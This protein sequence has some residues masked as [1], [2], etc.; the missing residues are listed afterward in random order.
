MLSRKALEV[1]MPANGDSLAERVQLSYLQLSSV[2]SD[3]NTVSD[4]LG[5][6]IAEIDFALKKL[7]L[8][9]SVWAKISGWEDELDYHR[10]ELGYAK[11]E[12]KWGIALRTVTGNYN[13]PDQDNIEQW[14][15]SD[16]PRRLRLASIETL[17][18][19][20]K[21]LSEEASETTNKIK[22]KLAEVKEVAAAVK[23]AAWSPKTGNSLSVIDQIEQLRK[24]VLHALTDGNQRILASM[25]EAGTWSLRADELVI[26]ITESQTVADMAFSSDARRLVMAAVSGIL[27]RAIELKL[28]AGVK[29]VT[30][31]SG[32]QGKSSGPSARERR[33]K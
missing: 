29:A 11:V 5:K 8:G 15:F 7:N 1:S 32:K 9:V 12:G 6:S 24:A 4:E 25:L 23:S 13:W 2:A 14:L 28:V 19:M 31:A 30:A 26:G 33:T 3:L 10:E 17:P 16:A 22:G 27:G 18:D 21:R 20:L